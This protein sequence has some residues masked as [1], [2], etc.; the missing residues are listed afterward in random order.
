MRG[1]RVIC[2]WYY[3]G[4]GRD[5][6]PTPLLSAIFSRAYF[7]HHREELTPVVAYLVGWRVVLETCRIYNNTVQDQD[8]RIPK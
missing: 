5:Y 4:L 2:L 3:A 7:T 1:S 6:T 8:A